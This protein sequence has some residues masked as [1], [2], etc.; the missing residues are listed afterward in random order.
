MADET[1]SNDEKKHSTRHLQ[2]GRK[3]I[4]YMA[5]YGG[6]KTLFVQIKGQRIIDIYKARGFVEID[7]STFEQLVQ[8]MKGG[9][10][11]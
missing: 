3:P 7:K 10:V 5:S 6:K 4:R 2:G 11:K 8:E 1:T 9:G